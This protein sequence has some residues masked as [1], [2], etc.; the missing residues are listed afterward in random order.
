M[1]WKGLFIITNV[2]VLLLVIFLAA[3]QTTFWFQVLGKFPSPLI[4]LNVVTFLALYR[5]PFNAIF[6]IYLIGYTL[7]RFTA[8]PFA[9]MS[10]SLLLLTSLILLVKKRVFW[11]GS[12]YYWMACLFSSFSFQLCYI[13]SSHFIENQATEI[14]FFDRLIQIMITPLFALPIYW[15][16][17]KIEKISDKEIAMESGELNG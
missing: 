13:I 14:L 1:N 15:I 12:G 4:W 5:N 7:C 2:L 8:M 16:M 6:M 9:L 11:P 3:F 10:T 17:N